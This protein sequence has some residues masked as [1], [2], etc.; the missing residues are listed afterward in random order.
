MQAALSEYKAAAEAYQLVPPPFLQLLSVDLLLQQEQH[1]QAVELLYCQPS[2]ATTMLVQHLARQAQREAGRG[3]GNGYGGYLG[4]LGAAGG[5]G[6]MAR[7]VS[8]SGLASAKT[9]GQDATPA[10]AV[11]VQLGVDA[12]ARQAAAEA[13]A[14]GAAAGYGGAGVYGVGAVGEVDSSASALQRSGVAAIVRGST[15]GSG[16]GTGRGSPGAKPSAETYIQQLLVSG[17]VVRAAKVAKAARLL[18]P[19]AVVGASGEGVS[20]ARASGG[21]SNRGSGGGSSRGSGGGVN[22]GAG[23]GMQVQDEQQQHLPYLLLEAAADAGEWGLFAAVYRQCLPV[24][25]GRWPS[26]QVARAHFREE[27]G[28]GMAMATAVMAS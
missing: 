10:A 26:L 27:A 4:A 24:L 2:T 25:C 13:I 1:Y 17:Q 15:G 3:G 12:A 22:D 5:G 20:G 21:G 23:A 9:L 6:S 19:Y 8:Q 28:G 7:S 14:A 18:A 16:G 11:A